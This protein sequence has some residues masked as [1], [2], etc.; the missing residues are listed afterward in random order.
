[1]QA[2]GAYDYLL[3][4]FGIRDVDAVSEAIRL[5]EQYLVPRLTERIPLTA[6]LI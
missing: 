1:M 6:I 5:L 3:K 4:S 2:L